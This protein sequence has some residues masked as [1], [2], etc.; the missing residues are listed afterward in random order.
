MSNEHNIAIFI[1][2]RQAGRAHPTYVTRFHSHEDFYWYAV[3]ELMSSGVSLP[4]D[5]S[6]DEICEALADSGIGTGARSHRHESY[7]DVLAYRDTDTKFIDCEDDESLRSVSRH[8]QDE[9]SD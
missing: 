6:L 2:T 9:F 8:Y 7:E 1:T 3:E 4:D 5:A